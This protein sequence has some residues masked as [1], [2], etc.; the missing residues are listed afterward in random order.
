MERL[1]QTGI[2]K[3]RKRQTIA[4]A[5]WGGIMIALILIVTT[6]WVS[7]SARIGTDQAVGR[8]SEFYLEEL[9]GRRSLVVSE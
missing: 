7:R 5:L 4:Y 2:N 1:Q 6:L 3:N 8:V 9:A